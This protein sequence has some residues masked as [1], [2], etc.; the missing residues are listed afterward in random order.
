[1]REGD[2]LQL[3]NARVG[4]FNGMNQLSL[5]YNGGYAIEKGTP[6]QANVSPEEETPFDTLK[7]NQRLQRTVHV[8]DVL[9]G[10]GYYVRCT[11]CNGKVQELQEVCPVCG[12]EGGIEARLLLPLLLDDGTKTLR[13]VAFEEQ[14]LEF[15]QMPKEKALEA[16]QT[17]EGKN[18][19]Q[20]ALL[21][22]R[23]R[24][25]GRTKLGMD[26]TSVEAILQE[27]SPLPFSPE[28]NNS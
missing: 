25:R 24:V 6:T 3:R 1:M 2:A 8:V 17:E 27:I 16:L 21:G 28:K 19:L 18:A 15:Y 22:K 26:G 9:A 11:K 12:K 4:T 14:A 13:G 5:G 10:R 23:F 20:H 7:E